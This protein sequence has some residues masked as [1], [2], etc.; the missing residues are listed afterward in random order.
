MP[1]AARSRRPPLRAVISNSD[2]DEYCVTT[3]PKSTSGSAPGTAQ[4]EYT[5]SA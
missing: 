3:S 5:L 1:V 4:V 2:F